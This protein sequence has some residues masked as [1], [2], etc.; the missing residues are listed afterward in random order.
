[1][2]SLY[3]AYSR[4]ESLQENGIMMAEVVFNEKPNALTLHWLLV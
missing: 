1:M 3:P 2:I 4:E